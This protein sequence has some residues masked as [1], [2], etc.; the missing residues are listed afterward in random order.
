M[1]DERPPV[2]KKD[3]PI[4]HMRKRVEVFDPDEERTHIPHSVWWA[5]GVVV[6]VALLAFLAVPA[7]KG[8][9]VYKDM[10]ASGV[11]DEYAGKMAMLSADKLAAETTA[12]DAVRRATD[13]EGKMA[14]AQGSLDAC[15][16][17]LDKKQAQ[18]EALVASLDADLSR[19]NSER[20]TC[21]EEKEEADTTVS[22]AARRICCARRVEDPTIDGYVVND[23]KIA[24]VAG[25]GTTVTC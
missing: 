18:S 20:D 24:C 22:D 11:P 17:D 9:A 12:A 10:K 6:I 23:G 15:R 16:E 21:L 2:Q 13:A 25:G 5:I 7:F 8:Y 14:A 1:A 19:A 4:T 3:V